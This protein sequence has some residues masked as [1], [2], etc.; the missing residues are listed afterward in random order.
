MEEIGGGGRWQ[1]VE[2]GREE[3]RERSSVAQSG[4]WGGAVLRV[5]RV[6]EESRRW[7]GRERE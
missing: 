5:C 1:D 6:L 2:Y 3:K 4:D 7:E